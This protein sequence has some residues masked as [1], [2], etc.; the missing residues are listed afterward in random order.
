ME[1]NRNHYFLAGLVLLFIGIQLRLVDTYVLTEQ[2]SKVVNKYTQKT[3]AKQ[4]QQLAAPV[5]M[6]FNDPPPLMA[7]AAERIR[8]PK[9]I[10]WAF[11]CV[12]IILCLHSLAMPR[13]G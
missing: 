3:K 6:F 2:A 8:P 5:A 4:Q 13:P 9:P 7:P 11:V 1:L 12:G 10:G